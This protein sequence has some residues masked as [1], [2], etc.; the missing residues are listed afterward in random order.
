MHYFKVFLVTLPAFIAVDFL[1]I[2]VLMGRFYKSELGP[3]A[4]RSGETLA[5]IWPA[6]I[7][8]YLLIVGGLMALVLPQLGPRGT[9]LQAALWG[10][11]FGLVLYG[12]HDLTNYATLDKWSLRMTLVDIVW[13]TVLSAA[14]A[15]VAQWANT[16]FD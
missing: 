9:L 15:V 6:A 16:W 10:S 8:T 14:T 1:W 3:L 2:G 5:P 13:G 11:L 4:R 12:V 7:V